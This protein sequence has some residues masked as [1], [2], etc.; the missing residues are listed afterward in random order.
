MQALP[1]CRACDR[2]LSPLCGG[3]AICWALHVFVSF[4]TVAARLI[5]TYPDTLVTYPPILETYFAPWSKNFTTVSGR[6]RYFPNTCDLE[7]YFYR[8]VSDLESDPSSVFKDLRAFHRVASPDEAASSLASSFLGAANVSESRALTG[9]EQQMAARD[10]RGR[11]RVRSAFR[12]L[13]ETLFARAPATLPWVPAVSEADA[14]WRASQQTQALAAAQAEEALTAANQARRDS[15]VSKPTSRSEHSE[16]GASL[17]K[18]AEE[19]SE[20]APREVSYSSFTSSQSPPSPQEES[21]PA[22]R[23]PHTDHPPCLSSLSPPRPCPDCPGCTTGA[24]T[25]A[26]HWS[27]ASLAFLG[28]LS[29]YIPLSS[30]FPP[31]QYIL[32]RRGVFSLAADVRSAYGQGLSSLPSPSPATLAVDAS[33]AQSLVFP[34]GQGR[35]HPSSSWTSSPAASA[36]EEVEAAHVGALATGLV[37]GAGGSESGKGGDVRRQEEELSPGSS[38]ALS[39]SRVGSG[40][41]SPSFASSLLRVISTAAP[42][43]QMTVSTQGVVNAPALRSWLFGQFSDDAKPVNPSGERREADATPPSPAVSP[44]VSLFFSSPASSVTRPPAAKPGAAAGE[45]VRQQGEADIRSL[46]PASSSSVASAA[47]AKEE[48]VRAKRAGE[49]RGDN[50]ALWFFD[51]CNNPRDVERLVNA[52]NTNGVGALIFTNTTFS[53]YPLTSTRSFASLEGW[54]GLLQASVARPQP[55]MPVLSVPDS[56]LSREIKERLRGGDLVEV[57]IDM[58]PADYVNCALLQPVKWASLVFIPLWAAPTLLWYLLCNYMPAYDVSP[59]HRLL[60]LPP[61]LKTLF[62]I[63]AFGFYAQCPN[64]MGTSTQYIMMAYMGLNTIF[65]TIFYGIL[66][67]LA[68]GFMVTREVFGRKESLSLAV[69]V[70]LVYIITSVNQVEEAET[71]PALLLL[72]TALLATVLTSAARNMRHLQLRLAYVRLVQVQD[73]E[74]ALKVKLRMFRSLYRLSAVFFLLQIAQKIFLFEIL[75]R[76]DISEIAG[77]TFEWI[78]FLLLS[79]VFRPREEILYFSLMQRTPESHTILPMYATGPLLPRSAEAG[80]E[81]LFE[82][83]EP[84]SLLLPPVASEAPQTVWS[85]MKSAFSRLFSGSAFAAD[86]ELGVPGVRQDGDVFAGPAPLR[87]EDGSDHN[88]AGPIVILNPAAHE[89]EASGYFSLQHIVVGTLVPTPSKN[90]AGDL[91]RSSQSSEMSPFGC[92]PSVSLPV[93]PATPPILSLLTPQLTAMD[94]YGLGFRL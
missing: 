38:E 29:A 70:S 45:E 20:H 42:W 93:H 8:D 86:H 94:L 78:F 84:F 6:M 17:E 92:Q 55:L 13:E 66:L 83:D 52:A 28:S 14:N 37:S 79:A 64:Y 36:P 41:R 60:L 51:E 32:S 22:V 2:L 50:K 77:S 47:F 19:L 35:M 48:E 5:I 63:A 30:H 57:D 16:G 72:Y 18:D 40:G 53:S 88:G 62:A 81:G 26:V 46:T 58:L 91:V 59:L 1:G 25:S 75:D 9:S 89:E 33:S 80:A 31:P 4:P 87:G 76:Q 39:A 24:A 67:L 11:T 56:R 7:H 61:L 27:A 21:R 44:L 82:G 12:R 23:E 73:W 3:L 69:L 85:R 15:P 65:N 68:K 54:K 71:L 10:A 90:V 49:F 34:V 43:L 74:E